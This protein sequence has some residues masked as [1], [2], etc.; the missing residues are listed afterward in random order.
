V[1]AV[2]YQ[3][4]ELAE[5]TLRSVAT[6]AARISE[7]VRVLLALARSDSN[8]RP[9]ATPVDVIAETRHAIGRATDAALERA[10]T[11]MACTA[12]HAPPTHPGPDA[13]DNDV[14]DKDG[15]PTPVITLTALFPVT[16]AASAGELALVLDNLL[17]N[18][19]RYA[20]TGIWVSVLPAGPMVRVIVEDDGPG[21][22]AADQVRVFDRFT[23]LDPDR[24]GVTGGA[25]L[26]LALVKALV[27]G[28]GGTAT[29][30]TSPHGGARIETRW[31]RGYGPT[32]R[33]PQ[34]RQT[35][36]PQPQHIHP[37]ALQNGF[38]APDRAQTAHGWARHDQG[39]WLHG[40]Y[41]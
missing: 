27:T 28:R 31:Q 4:S 24:G 35:R 34:H 41:T 25:G 11:A 30:S 12:K 8:A 16:A 20:T 37:V 2:L 36:T 38:T 18:A 19:R 33:P 32:P 9:P 26:G 1:V 17:G 40:C 3:N 15:E 29:M 39:S 21:V 6:E 7:L 22:P 10:I 23:R 13:P 5:D 14:E